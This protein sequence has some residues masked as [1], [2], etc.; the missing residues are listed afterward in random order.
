MNLKKYSP[1]LILFIIALAIIGFSQS[2]MDSTLNNFLNDVHHLSNLQRTLLEFPRELPGF[3]VVFISI[4]FF[5]V[6]TRK[7]AGVANFLAFLGLFL[8]AIFLKPLGLMLGCLFVYS[9]GQHVFLAL[10]SAI[11]ME[12]AQDGK[13]GKRLGQ[14]TAI[15][16]LT[17]IIGSA[18]IFLGF[19]YLHFTYQVS[20]FI[21]ATG[22][23]LATFAILKM[24]PSPHKQQQQ[25]FVF[26]KEYGLFYWLNI[27][28]GT[29]KQLFLTFAP[30]ILITVFHQTTA[31]MAA[32][33]TTGGIIGIFLKPLVGR[34]IDRFGERTV[35]LGEAASLIIVCVLYGYAAV[36]FSLPVATVIVSACFV[37]DQLLLSASMARATYLHKIAVKK[38]EV[39]P[40]LMMGLSLDHI[41]SITIAITC[42]FLWNVID[43]RYIFLFGAGIAGLNLLTLCMVSLKPKSSRV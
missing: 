26:R 15:T 2:L 21:A 40:T 1:D 34:A 37:T 6:G 9:L 19:R 3:F 10:N 14:L 18:F 30:W 27:V 20:F 35:L 8:I 16:N 7:L 23:L 43:Y 25:R 11:G 39:G 28:F 17:A 4:I 42:G 13:T 5:F 31:Q 12:L 24:A 29:R 33:L 22:F 36:W 38:E 41:F 32:L